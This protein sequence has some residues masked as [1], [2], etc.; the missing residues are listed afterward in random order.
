[1]KI[2]DIPTIELEEKDIEAIK[3]LYEL[4]KNMPCSSLN[5]KECPFDTVCDCTDK[6]EENT[7]LNI[8]K[9]LSEALIEYAETPI[10]LLVGT[11]AAVSSANVP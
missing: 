1:M 5:C 7:I 6:S 3:G 8:Q 9:A 11:F 10:F 2:I 4:I